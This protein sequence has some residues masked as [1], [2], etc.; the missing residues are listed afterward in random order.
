MINVCLVSPLP[1]P[2]GGIA[3][4]TS[5]IINYQQKDVNFFILNT[6][7]DKEHFLIDLLKTASKC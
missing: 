6:N 1:P 5:N 7:V 4:W 3:L 2:I